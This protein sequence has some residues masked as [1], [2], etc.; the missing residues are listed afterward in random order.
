MKKEIEWTTRDGRVIPIKDMSDSHLANTIN[1][2]VTHARE[3][4]HRNALMMDVYACDAPDGAAMCAEIEAE[5]LYTM[6]V[7][8]W[9]QEH[10]KYRALRREFQKRK[11]DKKI[12]IPIPSETEE[13]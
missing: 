9:L 1:Y 4:M 11:L 3:I 13:I 10:R 6:S 7:K 5:A 2:I 8:E 12:L